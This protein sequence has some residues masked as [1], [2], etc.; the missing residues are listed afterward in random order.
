M[1]RVVLASLALSFLFLTACG[2]SSDSAADL[3]DELVQ[4]AE[5]DVAGVYDEAMR[6]KNTGEYTQAMQLF[7]IIYDYEDAWEQY[8][9]LLLN[10]RITFSPLGFLKDDGTVTV[11]EKDHFSTSYY[12]T[13]AS[14]WTDI[15]SLLSISEDHVG[16][17]E[18]G[19]IVSTGGEG[20]SSIQEV[21]GQTG[22]IDIAGWSGWALGLRDDG[23]VWAS[24]YTGTME[25]N[26]G[27]YN[28][29]AWANI[30]D[31]KVGRTHSLG[32]KADG[33]VVACGNNERG[34]CDVDDWRDIVA[35]AAYNDLSV[36]LKS[37]GTVLMAGDSLFGMPNTSSWSD[38]VA[39]AVGGHVLGLKVDGTVVAAT[40]GPTGAGH[41]DVGSWENMVFVAAT[42][43]QSIGVSK[44]GTITIIGNTGWQDWGDQINGYNIHTG[45]K[46]EPVLTLP[47]A[48]PPDVPLL[49]CL[50]I[51]N[52]YDKNG[53][54]VVMFETGAT[55]D[56]AFEYYEKW[57]SER[58]AYIKQPYEG[59]LDMLVSPVHELEKALSIIVTKGVAD[60]AGENCAV[61]MMLQSGDKYES[62]SKIK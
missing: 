14:S 31:I 59:N 37:D 13:G 60:N 56:E 38:I 33:T 34:Q 42:S 51:L 52:A 62:V 6:L 40:T 4:N 41:C 44:D 48:F 45:E 24:K 25:S 55:F 39:I 16:I 11:I 49:E 10:D 46:I 23:T 47:D 21:L 53:E 54:V 5:E 18:S 2:T 7:M 29:S 36:G 8:N 26:K 9:G 32:L 20:L 57:C 58:G 3:A 28:V 1:R 61:I 30:R 27:Q 19:L 50:E 22:L 17:T 12:P 15:K 43:A 35:I